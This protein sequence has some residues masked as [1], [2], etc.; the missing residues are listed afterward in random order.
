MPII[1]SVNGAVQMYLWQAMC[2]EYLVLYFIKNLPCR[3]VFQ[4]SVIYVR[5]EIRKTVIMKTYVF[6]ETTVEMW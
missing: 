1:S 4:I 5:T 3:E 6:W 2:Y